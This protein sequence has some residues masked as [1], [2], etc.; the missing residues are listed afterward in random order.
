MS[1]SKEET[2][3]AKDKKNRTRVYKKIEL[4]GTSNNSFEDAIRNAISRAGETLSD[5]SWFEVKEFRGGLRNGEI[6]Y[7][8]VI[9]LSFEVK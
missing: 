8:A 1:A 9:L 7:Q 3:V 2:E 5:L 6:E 4:V